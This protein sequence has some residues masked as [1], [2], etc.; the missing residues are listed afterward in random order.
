MQKNIIKK[1]FAGNLSKGLT[2]VETLV[3]ISVLLMG[4]V[5]PMVI[6]SQSITSTRYAGDQI[7]AYY[8]AQE[9]I[10]LVKHELYSEFNS[11]GSWFSSLPNCSFGSSIDKCT[12]TIPNG[13]ICRS[14]S[15]SSFDPR[16][17]LDT[18][19]L[20]THTNTGIPTK[21]SRTIKFG[22]NPPEEGALVSSTVTWKSAGQ[23][24]SVTIEEYMTKWR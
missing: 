12:I 5:G 20:Y 16:L 15:C 3:A 13:T 24:K 11:G 14:G 10:E 7:T 19:N 8:L 17:Y 2:L 23:N 4:V 21:F 22:Q 1:Q 18:N 9:A 6:Y